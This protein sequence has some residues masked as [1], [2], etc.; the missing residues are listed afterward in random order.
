MKAA[1]ITLGCKVNQ[2]DTD[3]MR[4]LMEKAGYETVDFSEKADVYIINTCTVTNI[5]DRKSRQ[6]IRRAAETNRDAAICVT[7]CL[8][9]REK[10]AV[11]HIQGVDAVFGVNKRSSV[12]SV[13]SEALQ[14]KGSVSEVSDISGERCF[15]RLSISGTPRTRAYIKIEDGC[16][17]FCSYCII[18]YTRGRIRSRDLEDIENE[19]RAL[20]K[21]GVKEIV[22]TGI[23]IS[24]YGRDKNNA[25]LT[26]VIERISGVD[27]IERIRL[28]S[29][30]PTILTDGFCAELAR[31]GKLCPHFHVSLQSGSDAVLKRMNRHYTSGE[32]YDSIC[33]LRR[34]FDTPA[35][36]TDVIAGF[37]M[38][39]DEEH[40][41]TIE[42]LKK[43]N[44]AHV[45]VFPFSERAGTAAVKMG[46]AIPLALRK[47]RAKEIS[48]ICE[49]A[50]DAYAEQF[51][52][53]GVRVLFEEVKDGHAYG[54]TER[55]VKVRGQAEPGE[56]K[57]VMIKDKD[58][59]VL[60]S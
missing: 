48:D 23:H 34:F 51:V 28:G 5:A 1:Y 49:A 2:Y 36:T 43:V 30:E 11:L 29:L 6:M 52:G 37:N 17:N 42:F 21:G 26:D 19:A 46:G 3:A 13:V 25:G 20:A 41:E 15:E 40:A 14:K 33:G 58:G 24:S 7:G 59:S 12:V 16:D 60:I 50:E 8:A 53:R 10:E 4:E 31:F 44:F 38:E 32:Y 18:P 54:H 39:T 9:Q 22:I 56:I 35:I 47:Q 55:Y 27:G 45:H 57:E